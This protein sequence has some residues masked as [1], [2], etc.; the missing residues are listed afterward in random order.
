M[1][2]LPALLFSIAMLAPAAGCRHAHLGDGAGDSYRDA[3]QAQRESDAEG[4]DAMD[5]HDAKKVLAKHRDGK[6]SSKAKGTGS[7]TVTSTSSSS[8]GS[9]S[10]MFPGATGPIRLD[11]K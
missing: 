6:A 3:L 9:S 8:T 10:N 4:V 2:K 11:A 7:S 5:A 1:K